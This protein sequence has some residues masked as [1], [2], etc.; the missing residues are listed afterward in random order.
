MTML[1]R[2]VIVAGR[3]Q[4]VGFRWATLAEG[5][6]LGL[7]GWVRNLAD[8]RVEA[9]VQGEDEAVTGLVDWLRRGPRGAR[10]AA[11]DVFEA[12]PEAGLEGF[13]IRD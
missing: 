12:G 4:G 7:S 13:N 5:L 6:R 8:G 1:A 11:C 3:V 10:V 2:R 9:F